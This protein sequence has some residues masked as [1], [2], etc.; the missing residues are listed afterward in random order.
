MKKRKILFVSLCTSSTGELSYVLEIS[1]CLNIEKFEMEIWVNKALEKVVEGFNGKIEFYVSERESFPSF[2][3]GIL[4][5]I[6]KKEKD[7]LV[8]VDINGVIEESMG[9]SEEFFYS[10]FE[11]EVS[12]GI[13]VVV[14]D[15]FRSFEPDFSVVERERNRIK[16]KI[17]DLCEKYFSVG[18]KTRQ[19]LLIL[20]ELYQKKGLR[21][22]L[23]LPD[24]VFAIRPVP[25]NWP[26]SE[27]ENGR[28]FYVKLFEDF[29]EHSKNSRSQDKRFI[30]VLTS[31]FFSETICKEDLGTIFDFVMK[32]FSS[33]LSYEKVIVIDPIDFLEEDISKKFRCEKYKWL[34]RNLFREFIRKSLCVIGFVPYSLGG[35]YTVLSRNVFVSVVS[36]KSS[37]LLDLDGKKLKKDFLFFNALGVIGDIGF[38]E[39]LT[40]DNPYF[41]AIEIMDLG[42]VSS[43]DEVLARVK[44]GDLSK[45]D[46]YIN[47][48]LSLDLPDVNKVFTDIY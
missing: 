41:K 25:F 13:R 39:R 14:M 38:Y 36:S 21:Q 43:F 19:K 6:E 30:L 18:L 27:K 40:R 3:R 32:R 26:S 33:Y 15:Y 16:S 8:F 29:L 11:K 42:V 34:E 20:R 9:V 47:S 12:R 7:I 37:F 23:Y 45:V 35:C 48:Y 28:I 31:R 4:E 17:E 24:Q 10:F 22:V 5:K 44:E 1:K 2:F 46:R